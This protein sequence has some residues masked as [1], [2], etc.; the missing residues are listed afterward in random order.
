MQKSFG[1]AVAIGGVL[2]TFAVF[3]RTTSTRVAAQQKPI[4]VTSWDG[5]PDL[6]G[7]WGPATK[8]ESPNQDARQASAEERSASLKALESLYQPWA[9]EWT[10]SVGYLDD[11]R[12]RCGPYGFPR[13]ANLPDYFLLQIVQAP[14]ETLVLVEYTYSGFRIIPTDGSSH[15]ETI[16]PSYFGDSVGRWEGDTLVVDVTG[17]NGKIWLESGRPDAPQTTPNQRGR[18]VFVT[19]QQPAQN[20]FGGGWISSDALHEVERWRLLDADTLE[21]QATIEDPKLLTGPWTTPKYLFKRAPPDI[22]PH[23]ALCL[24]PEDLIHMKAVAEAEKK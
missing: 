6:T 22:V 23:E 19:K 15:P 20:N 13:Y 3:G 4:P 1:T 7:V 14:K 12:L 9:K 8:G 17:F 10:N 21:Y 16:V 5:K 18:N 24:Q 2:V 11:P